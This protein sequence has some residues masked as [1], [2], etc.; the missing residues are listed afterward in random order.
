MPL[1]LNDLQ[2]RNEK[3]NK[4][5]MK[6]TRNQYHYAVRHC[7]SNK[8]NIQKQRLAENIHNSTNFWR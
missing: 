6:H 5:I 4:K 8:L 3:I 7:K 2:R 1:T